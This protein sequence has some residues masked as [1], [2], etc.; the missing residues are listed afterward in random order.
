MD[1][2]HG[3]LRTMTALSLIVLL[4]F[5]GPS[6]VYAQTPAN[7][8]ES[9][10]EPPVIDHTPPLQPANAGEPYAITVIVTDDSGVKEVNLHYK[11]GTEQPYRVVAMQ[12][13]GADR[14][15]AVLPAM[16][17]I[18]P[19]MEYY[20]Q[21]MDEA[22]NTVFRGA[23]F[24]P[25]ILLVSAGAAPALGA[26]P[27]SAPESVSRGDSSPPLSS[28]P[29]PATSDGVDR[30]LPKPDWKWIVGGLLVFGLLTAGGGSDDGGNSPAGVGPGA[31]GSTGTVVINGP[32]P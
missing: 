17:V 19:Q 23:K 1:A 9:D 20:V 13:R 11:V 18:A 10:F 3:W 22:G 24:S 6:E 28:E 26:E 21:A 15:Q 4:S 8:A 25:L 27:N 5:A 16:D 2:L 12:H 7:S 29:A 30:S 32:A 14:Y 31:P